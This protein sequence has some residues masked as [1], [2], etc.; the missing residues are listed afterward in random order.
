MDMT[1]NPEANMTIEVI[2]VGYDSH[3][4]RFKV[5]DGNGKFV[6]GGLFRTLVEAQNFIATR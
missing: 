2:M 3:L 5:V 1:T 6:S 4:K